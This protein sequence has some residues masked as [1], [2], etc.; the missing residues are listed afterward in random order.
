MIRHLAALIAA[1]TIAV[2]S[3]TVMAAPT[4]SPAT[5]VTMTP[6]GAYVLGSTAAKV[7]LVEYV[8]YTCP[9][10]AHFI[11]EAAAPLKADYVATGQISVELR[12]LVRDPFDMTAALLARCGS[13]AKFFGNSEAIFAR[14][15]VWVADAQLLAAKQGAALK[16]MT[17]IQ[18]LGFIAN[19]TDLGAIMKGRGY[20]QP[21]INAC[22]AN[23]VAQNQLVLMT[24]EATTVIKVPFTPYFLINGRASGSSGSWATLEPA[25]KSA[26]GR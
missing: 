18:Q 11:E 21:Q 22:L 7:R 1:F 8:S 6:K 25:L 14:Q 9:H 2:S 17:A 20:T 15:A 12:N 5:M 3:M 10:C 24:R 26:I 23:K 16:K 19:N 4:V 13:A